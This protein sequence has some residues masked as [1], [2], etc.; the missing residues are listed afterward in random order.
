MNQ[1]LT[2]QKNLLHKHFTFLSYLTF[3]TFFLIKHNMWRDELHAW[4]I[5]NNSRNIFEIFE[6]SKYEG[7][8]PLY[9]I[10]LWPLT[11]IS[12][13][14]DLIKLITFVCTFLLAYIVIYKIR[15]NYFITLLTL[16]GFLFLA[17]YTRISRDYIIILLI[18][19]FIV[20]SIINN[21]TKWIKIAIIFLSLINL[22]G[23]ILG[24]SWWLYLVSTN[25]ILKENYLAF[26]KNNY[27]FIVSF[28]I[29]SWYTQPQGDGIAKIRFQFNF[30]SDTKSFIDVL[31]QV[32]IP[33]N[34][35]NSN[36]KLILATL[37]L[38]LIIYLLIISWSIN[39]NMFKYFVF[40]TPCLLLTYIY[41]PALEWWHRGV[42]TISLITSLLLLAHFNMK[43]VTNTIL[44]FLLTIV[45]IFQIFT[46]AFGIQS[47]IFTSAPYSNSKNLGEFLKNNCTGECKIIVTATYI[48]DSVSGYLGNT[49]VYRS[50]TKDFG[51]FANWRMGIERWSLDGIKEATEIFPH[52]VVV[53]NTKFEPNDDFLLIKSFTGAVLK[54][55]NFY[56]YKR[57]GKRE[58]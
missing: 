18:Q 13:N 4:L 49:R 33:N 51:T 16:S 41:S 53:S 11:Q 19:F 56:V 1:F 38:S 31:G 14:P 54:D 22:F 23:L 25:K 15:I 36:L 5:A 24:I 20:S 2:N 48:G 39:R 8:F 9:H 52:S 45:L 46:N 30:V 26:I 12:S 37:S 43:K 3:T 28:A 17:G 40:S 6:N 57:V 55:E 35:S 10:I 32:I 7:R 42:L 29:S 44:K 58:S 27:V 34:F 50:D 47:N 21:K